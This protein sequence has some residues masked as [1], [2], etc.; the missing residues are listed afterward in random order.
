MKKHFPS[1]T[2][3]CGSCCCLL[4]FVRI[5]MNYSFPLFTWFCKVTA[6]WNNSNLKMNKFSTAI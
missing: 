3:Q 1:L 6:F 5:L 2:K 4:R